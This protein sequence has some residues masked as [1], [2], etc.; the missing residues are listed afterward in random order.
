MHRPRKEMI[1]ETRAKL[2][3]A[4]R[5]AFGTIGYAEASM[6]DFTASA[7]LTRGALYHHFGDKKGLLQAVIAEIDGEMAV[8]VNEVASKAPTRWQHFVDECTTYI[9]MA[10]EPEIQRIMFRDGPAVLGDPAQWPNA[11]ACTAS[12][13]NHLTRLQEEGEVVPELDPETTSR[14]INGASSQAAQ[15]IANS[16]DP[17]ATSKKAITAFK[18]L[19]EGL[20]KKP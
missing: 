6:D 3:A 18:Q 2:I 20:R 12:M 9:E 13:T 11:S 8:R 16:T 4:A 14:L 5:H 15:R 17:E 7:G 10:L 1:A 19:L